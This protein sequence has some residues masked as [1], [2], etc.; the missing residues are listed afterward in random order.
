M[1]WA[2]VMIG[3]G[4]VGSA[5]MLSCQSSSC[6]VGVGHPDAV[7]PDFQGPDAEGILAVEHVERDFR[8]VIQLG[9]HLGQ[10]DAVDEG[11]RQ[12]AL[13]VQ[14]RAGILGGKGH[15]ARGPAGVVS[16][17]GV[18]LDAVDGDAQFGQAQRGRDRAV[19]LAGGAGSRKWR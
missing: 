2:R 8:L 15:R 18:V 4:L 7:V 17:A 11:A 10:R 9:R 6:R 5:V 19:G 14:H 16:V 3:G 12:Q 1:P 13:E